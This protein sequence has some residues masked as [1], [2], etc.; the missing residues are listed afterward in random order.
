LSFSSNRQDGGGRH[1]EAEIIARLDCRPPYPIRARQ[2]LKTGEL[3]QTAAILR[4]S[5]KHRMTSK[6]ALWELPRRARPAA[7]GDAQGD[8]RETW[9]HS[10]ELPS[11]ISH[12]SVGVIYNAREHGAHRMHR[13]NRRETPLTLPEIL[14][15]TVV[16]TFF[17]WLALAA[18]GTQIM[19]CGYQ[20]IAD[21]NNREQSDR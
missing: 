11:S 18:I 5:S 12:Q 1:A 6:R 16:I 15:R 10:I 14:V 7:E 21:S 2:V 4:L 20:E 17:V 3:S 8:N 13:R 9:S 19:S